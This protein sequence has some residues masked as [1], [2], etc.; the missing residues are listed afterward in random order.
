LALGSMTSRWTGLQGNFPSFLENRMEYF[1][2]MCQRA[3]CYAQLRWAG[4]MSL[5]FFAW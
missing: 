1:F 3:C 5:G 4:I 2:N